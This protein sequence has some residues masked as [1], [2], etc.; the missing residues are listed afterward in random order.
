MLQL[1]HC[2]IYAAAPCR[3]KKTTWGAF[4]NA[5]HYTSWAGWLMGWLKGAVFCKGRGGGGAVFEKG[6]FW[7]GWVDV[8]SM[9]ISPK[10]VCDGGVKDRGWG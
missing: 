3:W 9:Y 7:V 2:H 10:E 5:E 6:C 8:L 4:A 1:A